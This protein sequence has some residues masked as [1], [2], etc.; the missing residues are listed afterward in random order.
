MFSTSRWQADVNA[1]DESRLTPLHASVAADNTA[2]LSLLLDKG[3]GTE[4][5]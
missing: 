2:V 3:A 5:K 1:T 4:T